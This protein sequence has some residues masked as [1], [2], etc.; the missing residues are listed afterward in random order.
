M[1]RKLKK[2]STK[3]I[4]HLFKHELKDTHA[5]RRAM[6]RYLHV[7]HVWPYMGS[8]SSVRVIKCLNKITLIIETH[9]PGLL[10]GKG[11]YFIDGLQKFV[12]EDL[13]QK[14]HIRIEENQVWH[15][16]YK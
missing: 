3:V 7:R 8:I 9:R 11:G 12:E 5:Y 6:Y 10:I 15:N 4:E 1:K 2:I 14:I 16:L 13:N